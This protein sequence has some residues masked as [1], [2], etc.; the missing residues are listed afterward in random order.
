MN[1]RARDLNFLTSEINA[2]SVPDCDIVILEGWGDGKFWHVFLSH[3][4]NE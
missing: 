3:Y 1:G 4:T 2:E